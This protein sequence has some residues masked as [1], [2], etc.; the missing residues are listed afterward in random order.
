MPAAM[1]GK[2][3]NAALA[4]RCQGCFR[5]SMLAGVQRERE[6]E[7][8]QK[9]CQNRQV[10][11]VLSS[12]S[13]EKREKSSFPCPAVSRAREGRC[14]SWWFSCCKLATS[15]A[16]RRTQKKSGARPAGRKNRK[17]WST[18][19]ESA[20]RTLPKNSSAGAEAPTGSHRPRNLW[21]GRR[22]LRR[23]FR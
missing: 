21:G 15:L 1:A 8:E 13:G 2:R 17:S 14:G 16:G 5:S 10:R 11:A 23:T 22:C 7:R 9:T 3:Q 6:R 12:S 4:E 18:A 20:L 19:R